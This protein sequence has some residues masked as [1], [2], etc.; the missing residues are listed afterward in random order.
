[1]AGIPVFEENEYTSEILPTLGEN[2][3]DEDLLAYANSH[4]LV[5]HALKVFRGSIF[6]VDL[7]EK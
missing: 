2:P 1:V 7:T 5:K 4:P 3:T 6:A